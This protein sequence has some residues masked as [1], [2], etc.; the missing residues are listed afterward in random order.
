MS[1]KAMGKRTTK[2]TGFDRGRAAGGKVREM[3][4]GTAQL[5]FLTGNSDVQILGDEVRDLDAQHAL[6]DGGDVDVSGEDN[7]V[8]GGLLKKERGLGRRKQGQ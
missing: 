6:E 1:E 7:G 8:G 3:T 2:Y 4:L 5:E